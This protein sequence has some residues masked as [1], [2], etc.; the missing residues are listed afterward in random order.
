MHFINCAV[1]VDSHLWT[2]SS[3]G[4]ISVRTLRK[5]ARPWQQRIHDDAIRS[6]A[7]SP[8]RRYVLTT[9]D[10]GL[11]KIISTLPTPTVRHSLGKRRAYM[12]TAD[13]IASGK[14]TLFAVGKSDGEILFGRI[15]NRAAPRIT[16]RKVFSSLIRSIKYRTVSAV[17]CGLDNGT[18]SIIY[19]A[20]I[21]QIIKT[22]RNG[23]VYSLTLS[24]DG[25]DVWV[26]RK[27]GSVEHRK[28]PSLELL[29]MTK[30]HSSIVGDIVKSKGNELIT[31][32]DDR[33][34][35]LIRADSTEI[36][37][38]IPL[39]S[40]A[41]NNLIYYED[42]E[43]LD[44]LVATSDDCAVYLIDMETHEIIAKYTE[45]T[46]PVR[47]AC[48]IG[49]GLIATGDRAGWVHIWNL[50]RKKTLYRECFGSRI[51]RLVLDAVIRSLL[52]FTERHIIRLEYITDA[53]KSPHISRRRRM[54]R[55]IHVLHLSD[56][57]FGTDY[58]A[59]SWQSQLAEDL[60]NELNCTHLDSIIVSGDIGNFA[61]TREYKSAL[62]FFELMEEEFG[63]DKKDI[64]VVPGNHDVDWSKSE[65]A[66]SAKRR[67][68]YRGPFDE[69]HIIDKGEYV[70][71]MDDT[72]YCTRFSNFSEFMEKLI[73]EPYSVEYE[74]QFSVR[75]IADGRILLMGYNSAW[76]T[77]HHYRDRAG[78]HSVAVANA[79]SEIRKAS[80]RRALLK[81]AVW[82]H[83][84]HSG[85]D[86]RIKDVGYLE[87]LAKADFKIGLHGH[88]HKSANQTFNYDVGPGGRKMECVSAGTFGAPTRDWSPGYP[89]QY[90]FL[91][92]DLDRNR[93][94]VETRRREEVNGAWK[95]DAR[96]TRGKG[97]DPEPRYIIEY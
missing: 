69:N 77:D 78:I 93:V 1:T 44:I 5:R 89:L 62:K 65:Q 56:L 18:L 70:E 61:T 60:R 9:S 30:V 47:S 83:P 84:I 25:R 24:K 63:L 97:K 3:D 80:R 48:N 28:L 17:V 6:L 75:E 2:G 72:V 37:Q 27:N 29:S 96:W 26:G 35:T 12:V 57:H 33:I 4:V 7:V 8:D 38:R 46:A 11:H 51:T 76:Q 58:D 79:L 15:V 86:S 94:T 53:V 92:I 45:H 13:T 22:S 85:E 71:V 90:N 74:K 21:Q 23:A 87:Q 20:E 16:R 50:G 34:I 82:H 36:L 19:K 81:I 95:P 32:S 91:R 73:G 43:G 54:T 88:I 14:T 67:K 64:L 42:I 68:D 40:A 59:K 55:Y 66:Y 10:D 31:C 41:I 49:N 39:H 52:V